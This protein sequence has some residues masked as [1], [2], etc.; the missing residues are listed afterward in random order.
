L[1]WDIL[2]NKITPAVVNSGFDS[3]YEYA[4]SFLIGRSICYQS[5]PGE[6]LF[7]ISDLLKAKEPSIWQEYSIKDLRRI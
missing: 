2:K 5:D 3:W 1:A 4:A 7:P 6:V